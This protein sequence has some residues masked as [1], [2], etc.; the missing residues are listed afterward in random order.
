MAAVIG[1]PRDEVEAACERARTETGQVVSPANYNAP[2]Q[3]VI[4]GDAAAVEI[5]CTRAR[6]RGA[7][8]C[9]APRC[10]E[11]RDSALALCRC[12]SSCRVQ[13][14]SSNDARRY[15]FRWSRDRCRWRSG[16][17]RGG[18]VVQ[19]AVRSRTPNRDVASETDVSIPARSGPEIRPT[20]KVNRNRSEPNPSPQIWRYTSDPIIITSRF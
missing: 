16:T 1:S 15:T 6:E 20:S 19:P 7:K 3:T 14:T 8:R 2:A 13:K 17:D 4:A 10:S 18:V 11:S 9:P 5:A 12:G